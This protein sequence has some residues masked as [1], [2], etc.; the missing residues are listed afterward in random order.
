MKY[1]DLYCGAVAIGV[2]NQCT[3]QHVK[4]NDLSPLRSCA[5]L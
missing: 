4:L 3:M 1:V 2:T 5:S